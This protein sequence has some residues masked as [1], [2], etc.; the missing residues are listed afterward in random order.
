MDFYNSSLELDPDDDDVLV[1]RMRLHMEAGRLSEAE[2]DLGHLERL[3]SYHAEPMAKHL[4][5]AMENSKAGDVSE[6]WS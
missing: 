6:S 5:K 2:K 4:Q 1:A 3:Q